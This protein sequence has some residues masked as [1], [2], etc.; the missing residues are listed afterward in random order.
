ME[1]YFVET[2][3]ELFASF[4]A[5]IENA[6]ID[7]CA[8][9]YADCLSIQEMAKR[10]YTEEEIGKY[11]CLEPR[12]ISRALHKLDWLEKLLK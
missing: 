3:I 5:K 2:F 1:N 9:F 7:C 4:L 6:K 10:G 11:L 8:E 12:E